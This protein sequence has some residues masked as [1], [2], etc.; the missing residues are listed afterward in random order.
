MAIVLT[1]SGAVDTLTFLKR[2]PA[3]A[4]AAS[5]SSV[6]ISSRSDE[7]R[8]LTRTVMTRDSVLIESSGHLASRQ[9]SE[10]GGG[11]DYKWFLSWGESQDDSKIFEDADTRGVCKIDIM[12][13]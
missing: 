11:I 1:N 2:P 4:R 7:S 8:G 3:S 13:R 9:E 12:P 10:R 5:S 6:W